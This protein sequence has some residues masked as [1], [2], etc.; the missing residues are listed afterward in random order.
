[1]GQLAIPANS[2]VY[3]DTSPIIYTVEK[4]ADYLSVLRTLWLSTK[5]QEYV[6]VTSSLTLLET[7]VAPLREGN[8]TLVNE[9][10][11]LLTKTDIELVPITTDVL[12]KAAS[13]RA[14]NNLKTPDAIHAASAAVASCDHFISN[15]EGFRRLSDI[16]VVILKDHI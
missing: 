2:R 12:R 14:L 9:Y 11:T 4:H 15:D 5:N 13:I 1:M 10:E 16:E 7:L 3:L 8:L 6:V